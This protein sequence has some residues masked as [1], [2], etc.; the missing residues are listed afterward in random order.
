MPYILTKHNTKEIASKGN[1]CG[2]FY[3]SKGEGSD[4]NYIIRKDDVMKISV[5]T[6]IWITYSGMYNNGD[7]NLLQ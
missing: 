1:I 5:L 2:T 3:M 6:L 4:G 7:T